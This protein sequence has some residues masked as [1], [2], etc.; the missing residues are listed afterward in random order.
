[1]V[2][3]AAAFFAYAA[4]AAYAGEMPCHFDFDRTEGNAFL[5]REKGT[6]AGAFTFNA[7]YMS[8]IKYMCAIMRGFLILVEQ[9]AWHGKV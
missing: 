8:D 9:E 1:M 5:S 4:F 2:R 3:T 7:G 6:A